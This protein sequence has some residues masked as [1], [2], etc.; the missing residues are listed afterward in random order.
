MS[1][2]EEDLNKLHWV[3]IQCKWKITWHFNLGYVSHIF[4]SDW[5]FTSNV[6]LCLY[7]YDLMMQCWHV[8]PDFR[9]NFA[10]VVDE[11][12]RIYNV[13]SVQISLFQIFITCNFWILQNIIFL[14]WSMFM[15]L[16]YNNNS[17]RKKNYHPW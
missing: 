14:M 12:E 5:Q 3:R 2:V 11:L 13:R 4:S 10:S 9:P 17:Y 15:Y 1:K 16:F 7:R 6:H 8:N